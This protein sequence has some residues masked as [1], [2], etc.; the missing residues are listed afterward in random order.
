MA[1][2]LELFATMEGASLAM[3]ELHSDVSGRMTKALDGAARFH[4]WGKHYLRAIS[5]SH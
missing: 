3:K 4:R 2:Q 1:E 5:R